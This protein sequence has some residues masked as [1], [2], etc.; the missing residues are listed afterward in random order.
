MREEFTEIR[1]FIKGLIWG[2]V[3]ATGILIFLETEKGKEIKKRLKEEGDDFL[4]K[5]PQWLEELEEKGE[6]LVE[7]AEKIE[8]VIGEE[9][10]KEEE[11]IKEQ[12]IQTATETIASSLDHIKVIQEH[13]REIRRHL[14]KNIPKRGIPRL[15]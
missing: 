5:L 9:V 14:F 1:G 12:I 3:L 10:K 7:K 11:P 15:S 8:N 4:E 6:E 13:G 2:A